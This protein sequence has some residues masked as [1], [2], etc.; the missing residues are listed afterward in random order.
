MSKM[1]LLEDTFMDNLKIGLTNDPSKS[2]TFALPF[3]INGV[4]YFLRQ[5]AE[6]TSKLEDEDRKATVSFYLH[7]LPFLPPA[8][9]RETM[10]PLVQSISE[11][12][13]GSLVD[14]V[15]QIVLQVECRLGSDSSVDASG[16]KEPESNCL[17]NRL[18]ITLKE[19]THQTASLATK[20]KLLVQAIHLADIHSQPALASFG[21]PRPPSQN[22]SGSFG[23]VLSSNV[24]RLFDTLQQSPLPLQDLLHS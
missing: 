21:E 10:A 14:D 20:M 3:Q 23:Q 19:P 9:V 5:Y 16:C 4:S 8:E 2:E 11:P 24:H 17:F 13:I 15:L 7:I 1:L 22:M 12:V 18:L 6:R